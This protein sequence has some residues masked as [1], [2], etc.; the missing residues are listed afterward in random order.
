VAVDK[1]GSPFRLHEVIEGCVWVLVDLFGVA[2]DHGRLEPNWGAHLE[3]DFVGVVDLRE[4]REGDGRWRKG[5]RAREDDAINN[6]LWKAI[7][8]E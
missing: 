2:E 3:G 8:S 5:G 7:V 6:A 1:D 4:T